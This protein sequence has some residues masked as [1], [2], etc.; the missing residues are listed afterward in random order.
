[1][2]ARSAGAAGAAAAAAIGIVSPPGAWAAMRTTRSMHHTWIAWAEWSKAAQGHRVDD[3]RCTWGSQ[4]SDAC[5]WTRAHRWSSARQPRDR[6]CVPRHSCVRSVP[7]RCVLRVGCA[8]WL[9]MPPCSRADVGK[10]SSH[11]TKKIMRTKRISPSAPLRPAAA[12]TGTVPSCTLDCPPPRHATPRQ[13]RPLHSTPLHSSPVHCPRSTPPQHGRLGVVRFRATGS[14]RTRGTA[15]RFRPHRLPAAG[16]TWRAGKHERYNTTHD[17]TT[18]HNKQA[19][20]LRY[21]PSSTAMQSPDWNEWSR[22]LRCA[23][24]RLHFEHRDDW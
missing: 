14:I 10:N 11:E 7:F 16:T 12:G 4:L 17:T 23:A 1:M 2:Y 21:M 20:P 18:R 13:A 8:W 19:A 22:G 24:M 15:R 9:H 6:R 3:S 5:H